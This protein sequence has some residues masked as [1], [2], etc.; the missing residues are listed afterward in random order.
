MYVHPS[1]Q[2]VVMN[3]PVISIGNSKG[4]RIPQP[5]LKQCNIS[6]EVS[7]EVRDSEIV[8]RKTIRTDLTRDFD[9][10]TEMDDMTVQLMLRESDPS[11]LAMSLV[12]APKEVKAKISQ[13][14]SERARA[15]L[16]EKIASLEKLD[17]RG[18]VVEMH[19]FS[20]NQILARL[21]K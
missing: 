5:F 1:F 19:K 9:H 4:I 16:Q 17:A 8:L 18:L 6:D 15:I 20:M 14:M 21:L 7:M 11:I 10:V 12:N 3:I 13:N 2:E